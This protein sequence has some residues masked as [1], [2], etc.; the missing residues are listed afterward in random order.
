L[1]NPGGPSARWLFKPRTVKVLTAPKS[2]PCTVRTYQRGEDWAE[3]V[4]AELAHL[5]GVPAALVELATLDG[6]R[7]S[8]SRDLQPPGWGMHGGGVLIEAVDERYQPRTDVDKRANRVGHNLD[9]VERV[10]N[11]AS[12]PPE[13]AY[14]DWAAFDVF[15][16]FLA[17]DA[18]IANTDRHEDNW[19]VLHGPNGELQLAP[20]FDH[21]SALGSGLMDEKRAALLTDGDVRRWCARGSAHRFEGM[22]STT[23]VDLARAALE[24][25]SSPARAYWLAQL[26]SVGRDACHALVESVPEMSASAR[27]FVIDLLAVNQ[28]RI[29]S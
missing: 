15:A 12:G 4:A 21:G 23:L 10:L 14:S 1:S 29:C 22:G 24:R 25:T 8:M 17:F 7:G 16:G 2:A 19:Q 28:E 6:A 3:K 5:A 11:G 9:N 18:W 13:T 26:A 27:T 20:S